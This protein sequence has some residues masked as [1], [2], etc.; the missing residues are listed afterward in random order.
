MARVTE[1]GYIGIG[2]KDAAA[3][4]D[5]AAQVL[6][7]EVLDEGEKDVFYL[8]MDDWHH[9][10]IVHVNGSDD[11]EYLGWRVEGPAEMEEMEKQ[12]RAAKVD[13]RVASEQEARERH[14]LGLLKLA[15]PGGNPLE[16]FYGPHIETALPFYPGRRRY[17]GFLT[18]NEGIGHVIV[19]QDDPQKAYEFYSKALGMRGSIEYRLQIPGGPVATPCFMHCNARDH[20]IAFGVG[21]MERRMNHLMIETQKFD[22]VGYT[23]DIVRK[24]KIPIAID[25]GKHSNDQMTSF[26]FANPSGWL[27]ELGWGAR[28]ATHSVEYYVSDIWGHKV[29]AKGF[30]MDVELER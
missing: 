19:R 13:Y 10:I 18:E 2:V 26:Y 7:M 30:G 22:D 15:D 1:L 3:W 16:I 9:R 5:Y 21:P 25:L 29:Q 23:Y 4:K 17:A 6:G 28:K 11:L 20:S 8:R 24:R 27:I 14:V 12:L